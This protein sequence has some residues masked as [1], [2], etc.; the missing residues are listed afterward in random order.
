MMQSNVLYITPLVPFP[1]LDVGTEYECKY[2][3]RGPSGTVGWLFLHD[4]ITRWFLPTEY[5]AH[6][7]PAREGV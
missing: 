3:G 2:D 5:L 7:T 1:G 4:G 6:R